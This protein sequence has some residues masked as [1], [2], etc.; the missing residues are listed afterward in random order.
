MSR[1]KC[2][3]GVLAGRR[4]APQNEKTHSIRYVLALQMAFYRHFTL[5]TR[6]RQAIASVQMRTRVLLPL[7][8]LALLFSGCAKRKKMPRTPPA[9]GK[10]VET[11][12]ASWYGYPYD[13]RAT[14]SG[15]IYDMEKFTA[16]HST[17]PFQTWVRVENLSNHRSVDVRINDRGPFVHGR[18]ID[19]SRAAARRIE[20]LGP[21]TVKV[22]L[23]S[24]RAPKREEPARRPAP[25]PEREA[26]PKRPPPSSRPSPFPAPAQHEFY[27]V[28]AGAFS[29]RERAER[30]REEME[31]RHG[32]ARLVEKKGRP[33][34]WRVL[35][36][37]QSDPAR[38]AALASEI[39]K[40]FPGAFVVHLDAE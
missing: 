38:V 40:E 24:I 10:Y 33:A 37:E 12:M 17:L 34:V 8:L 6:A 2:I 4:E 7:L 3:E 11:G 16:A 19:L 36:G 22:R 27:A 25:L 1:K 15:E 13:G 39:R 21:G 9:P 18:I 31:R 30:L 14:S 29:D 32:K 35:V 26:P 28:Q 20:L 23:I 5:A